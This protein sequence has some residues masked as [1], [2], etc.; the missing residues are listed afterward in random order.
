MP[1]IKKSRYLASMETVT[2]WIWVVN[3]S[4]EVLRFSL[5][6]QR[7]VLGAFR[8]TSAIENAVFS[9]QLLNA[10]PPSHPPMQTHAHGVNRTFWSQTAAGGLGRGPAE[11]EIRHR[12]NDRPRLPPE[13]TNETLKHLTWA[14]QSDY[15]TASL[16]IICHS[17]GRYI[18]HHLI[19]QP[20]G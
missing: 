12:T 11:I 5:T 10:S 2:Y 13:M 18:I 3:L 4:L 15:R 19:W 20:A 6:A 7:F 9:S 1:L 8:R 17:K 16:L 14:D